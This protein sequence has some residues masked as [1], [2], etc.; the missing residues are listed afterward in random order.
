[1]MTM[2]YIHG[3]PWDATGDQPLRDTAQRG[4]AAVY[5][6]S[7]PTHTTASSRVLVHKE[8]SGPTLAPRNSFS[9]GT[10]DSLLCCPPV[11]FPAAGRPVSLI[12][13]KTSIQQNPCCIW[14]DLLTAEQPSAKPVTTLCRVPFFS[15]HLCFLL[16]LLLLHDVTV[17]K[18]ST[19]AREVKTVKD[20]S[21]ANRQ[22]GLIHTPY[23]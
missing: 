1:M 7:T 4:Y 15:S 2:A 16:L 21:A 18:N 9:A 3:H 11:L 14:S 10:A 23:G 13:V 5:C 22:N 8:F 6:G 20:D 19:I 12:G 17:L